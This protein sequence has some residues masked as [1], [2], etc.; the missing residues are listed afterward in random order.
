[1]KREAA[2]VGPERR[3]FGPSWSPDPGSVLVSAAE[4][5]E[6]VKYLGRVA[7]RPADSA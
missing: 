7:P 6:Q 4:V 2:R 1:M 3:Q 5:K